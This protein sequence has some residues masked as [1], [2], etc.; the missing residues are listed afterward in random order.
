[1]NLKV[2]IGYFMFYS[3]LTEIY[4]R[5]EATTKRL[6]MIGYLIEL[7]QKT[8]PDIMDKI[9]Y[10]TQG[11][12]Q[13]DFMGLEL[14]VGEKLTMRALSKAT[15]YVETEVESKMV[16]LGDLGLVA[17]DLVENKKQTALFSEKLS[18]EKVYNSFFKIANVTGNK[19]QDLKFKMIAELIHDSEPLEAKYIVRSLTGKIRLGIADMTILSA[20]SQAFASKDDTKLI[21]HVYNIYPDLGLLGKTLS[22]EG[23][24][25]LQNFKMSVGIPIRH[26]LAER[27]NSIE[28]ILDKLGGECIFEYK[29]D[30]LRVQAHILPDKVSL[31]S[32]HLEEISDQFPD[33]QDILLNSVKADNAIVE[34][35]CVPINIET[36]ELLPFQMV[37][38]RRGRKYEIESA[39]LDFP[40][41]LFLFDCLYLNGE[42]ITEQP[43]LTRRNELERIINPTD[44]VE[45]SNMI[46]TENPVKAEQFFIKSL[47]A[48]C[49]GLMAKNIADDSFYKSGSR[50]WHWIKYK[51]EYKSE[52]EDTLDLVIVGAFAGRGRRSGVYGALLMAVYNKSTDQ[53]ETICKLGTGFSDEMLENISEMLRD[54][55]LEH[56]H[57]RVKSDMN[58]DYWIEPKY[59]FEVVGAEISF[60]PIH[61]CAYGALKPDAGLAIRFPRF[62]GR[63]RDDKSAEDATSTDE[64]I[65]MYN[66]QLKRIE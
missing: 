36:G 65:N 28:E 59:V 45:L 41:K 12:V 46:K 61:T 16:K 40:I 5:I 66:N 6:E 60:S 31:F 14:G 62:T 21:E 39:V 18:I 25:G 4:Q 58:A 49:E 1:M 44:R 48:G 8:P 42:D 3:E 56:I 24:D 15:G 51:R 23:L 9:I 33:V 57:P 55:K 53:Y 11:K 47:E 38:R 35:E 27:L 52:L 32:R 64:I 22:L 20:L 10:L 19:S 17:H 50:G 30:G 13:P 29:Y 2:K 43:L 37:S 7:F 34:G 54:H 63:V 26:M